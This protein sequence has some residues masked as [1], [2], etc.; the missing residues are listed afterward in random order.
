MYESFPSAE[1]GVL[2]P[3][4]SRRNMADT[5]FDRRQNARIYLPF[6]AVVEGVNTSGEHFK[7]DTVL[8]NLSKDGLY[9]RLFPSVAQGSEIT[10]VFRLSTAAVETSSPRVA[11]KGTVLRVDERPGG[12]FGIAIQFK[13]PRFI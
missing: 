2:D 9:V 11:I 5:A 7:V 1:L 10:V 3:Y 4:R 12:A 6:P 13:S 8:D